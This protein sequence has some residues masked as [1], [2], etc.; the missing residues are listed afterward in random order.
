MASDLRLFEK[1]ARARA[2]IGA[3]LQESRD[4]TAAE[5]RIIRSARKPGAYD[6]FV[7]HRRTVALRGADS[8]AIAEI[9]ES[10]FA[11]DDVCGSRFDAI[12]FGQLCPENAHADVLAAWKLY[13]AYHDG[14]GP[15]K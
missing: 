12:G 15:K 5:N 7:A 1:F 10:A 4:Y 14:I 13:N 6:R 9:L 8:T 2:E 3:P 11:E